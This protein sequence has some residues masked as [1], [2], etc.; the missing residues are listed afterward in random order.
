MVTI[1][2]ELG[3]LDLS[4]QNPPTPPPIPHFQYFPVF[5]PHR[6]RPSVPH[7]KNKA[8]RPRTQDIATPAKT[9]QIPQSA[10]K[11]PKRRKKLARLF[12]IPAS[13]TTNDTNDGAQPGPS[14]MQQPAAAAAAPTSAV[15]PSSLYP[16]LSEDLVHIPGYNL[17]D[18][19]PVDYAEKLDDDDVDMSL[20]T[21]AAKEVNEI[22]VHNSV[23]TRLLTEP[24]L[25]E[26]PSTT[27]NSFL[28]KPVNKYFFGDFNV[29][30]QYME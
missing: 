18:R 21:T 13:P 28:T 27:C 16:D 25:P 15:A 17:R 19:T 9:P 8:K 3:E 10:T 12:Y 26:Q 1:D 6:L 20:D 14:D 30:D 29:L 4:Y 22:L 24:L 7:R 5:W 11:S 2:V 23:A